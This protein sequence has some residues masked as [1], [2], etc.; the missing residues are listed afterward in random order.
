MIL[1]WVKFKYMALLNIKGV[2]LDLLLGK[3][4]DSL[5]ILMLKLVMIFL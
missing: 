4:K 1:H 3:F 2:N 5:T